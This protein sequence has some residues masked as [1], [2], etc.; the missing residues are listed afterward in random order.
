MGWPQPKTTLQNNNTTN[1]GVTNFTTIAKG[2]K[3]L[4]MRLLLIRYHESQGQFLFYWS[5]GTA[6]KGDYSTKHHPPIYHEYK[7]AIHA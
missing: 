5:Q 6:N 7:R 3:S 2:I 1:V 4:D